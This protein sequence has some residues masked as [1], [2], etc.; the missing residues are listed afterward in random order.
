MFRALG[1]ANAT[2]VFQVDLGN[3]HWQ[4]GDRDAATAA[5]TEALHYFQDR[6]PVMADIIRRALEG[7]Y[8]QPA[9]ESD[10]Q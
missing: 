8:A 3:S 10:P 7:G 5:W 9:R 4:A 6:V 1:D 2:A